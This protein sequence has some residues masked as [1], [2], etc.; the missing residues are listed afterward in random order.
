MPENPASA[1]FWSHRYEAGRT[2]W[3]GGGE[4]AALTRYL[5]AHPGRGEGV[6][7]PGCGSG[8]EI[9]AFTRAGYRVTA[10]DFSPPAAAQARANVGPAL[11]DCVVEGDFFTYDFPGAPFDLVY[12]RTFLCALP[13][14]LWPKI[15]AR[16]AAL[17]KPGGTLAGIFLFGEKAEGP[18]YG[19]A[20]GEAARLFGR[21]FI[22]VADEPIAPD[23]SLPLFAGHE[24]WQER[25]RLTT[26]SNPPA[27]P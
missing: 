12:E 27:V 17:L 21:Q 9:T 20:P 23:E 13:P 25:R 6:L 19:L 22:L 11:A 7:I 14:D 3:D 16:I 5:A 24:R 1:E 18:P 26:V 4:P 15:A 8:H 10:I 2:P